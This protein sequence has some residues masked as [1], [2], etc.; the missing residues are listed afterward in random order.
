[1]AVNTSWR[2]DIRHTVFPNAKRGRRFAAGC[3]KGLC[4]LRS[5]GRWGK[6]LYSRKQEGSGALRR[7]GSSRRRACGPW[8]SPV[9]PAGRYHH[10]LNPLNPLNLLNPHAQRACPTAI[11]QPSGPQGPSNLRTFLQPFPADWYLSTYASL[12]SCTEILHFVQNDASGGKYTSDSF[13]IPHS[14][15]P[16]LQ[17]PVPSFLVH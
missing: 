6:K 5:K 7:P 14:P 16:I 4:S 17:S 2:E 12:S 15:F 9:P 11:P 10:P 1:M 3:I 8:A 13:S